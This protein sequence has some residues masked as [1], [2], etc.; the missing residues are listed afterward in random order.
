GR[1]DARQRE[2]AR[3]RLGALERLGQRDVAQ[4]TDAGAHAGLVDLERERDGVLRVP[5]RE[6]PLDRQLEVV[7]LVEA[8]VEPVG[9]AAEH[10]PDDRLPRLPDRRRQLDAIRW[11]G[12]PPRWWLADG[13]WQRRSRGRR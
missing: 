11:H 7:E 2:H 4:R 1:Q 3:R 8:E 9:D 13:W 5:L 12:A 10:H 6:Q